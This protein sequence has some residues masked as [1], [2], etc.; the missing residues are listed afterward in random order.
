MSIE[1]RDL[2]V[3]TPK[4][5]TKTIL[6]VPCPKNHTSLET[7]WGKKVVYANPWIFVN[8]PYF[9]NGCVYLYRQISWSNQWKLLS[10][11]EPLIEAL[12]AMHAEPELGSDSKLGQDGF[13]LDMMWLSGQSS[14][15]V[16]SRNALYQVFPTQTHAVKI[17]KLH[18]WPA[19]LLAK[20]FILDTSVDSHVTCSVRMFHIE[21]QQWQ[22]WHFKIQW[23]AFH[24]TTL[25][26]E[27]EMD[28][29]R[30]PAPWCK[31]KAALPI[32]EKIENWE[33][34]MHRDVL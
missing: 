8:E 34:L 10:V 18:E 28:P 12:H 25:N 6:P 22:T 23:D 3:S 29:I 20:R 26:V 21:L 19:F 7:G 30:E 14:L 24:H 27:K 9:G 15:L 33:N 4:Q 32:S 11:I 5:L 1:K 13:G 31:G 16:L 17:Q 2:H